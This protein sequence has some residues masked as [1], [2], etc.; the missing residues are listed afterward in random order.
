[1]LPGLDGRKMSK[2]YDNVIPC[3][4][5]AARRKGVDLCDGHQLAGRRASPRIDPQSSRCSSSTSLAS[6]AET[7]AAASGLCRGIAWVMPS[8]AC[9][10]A[11][12]P[13][14]GPCLASATS[15]C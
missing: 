9:S 10:S 3:S 15:I 11:S 14:P 5:P 12:M 6:A 13:N 2:S 1:M 4:C 7:E 8:N